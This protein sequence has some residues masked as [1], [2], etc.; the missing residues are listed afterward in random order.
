M[1]Y[2][3]PAILLV[4]VMIFANAV[5]VRAQESDLKV[6]D[7]VVAQVNE[8]VITLSRIKREMK[9]SVDSLVQ[10]GKK[11]EDAQKLV[12]QKRGEL[13]ANLI[14]EELLMQRG[15][16]LNIEQDVEA[17][18][19]TRFVQI[20][21]QY[22]LKTIEQLHE[23]MTKQGIDP[24]ELRETWR[25][26]AMREEVFR[27]EVQSKVYWGATPTELKEYYEKNKAKFTKPEKVTLSEIFLSFAGRDPEAVRTKAKQLVAQLRAGADFTKAVLDNSDRPG[28][29]E[30][31]GKVDTFNVNDLDE[32]YRNAVAKVKVGGYTDPIEVDAVGIN[33][34]RVDDRTAASNESQFDETAVRLAI[35]NE[36]TPTETKKFMSKL[37]EDAYIKIS[38]TYRPEVSPILFAEERSTKAET[39]KSGN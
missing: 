16:E 27:R 28:A 1:R 13:I 11:R 32:Q 21:K 39:K 22:N 15:K 2:F 31:K 8:G 19:N 24:Q 12:D 7:E 6:V 17:S 25:R 14:N 3:K 37:R 30:S 36:K 10:E 9:N 18:L 33:I 5:S 34:L 4:A 29:A 26:Q 35:L 23:E 20:M 38:D